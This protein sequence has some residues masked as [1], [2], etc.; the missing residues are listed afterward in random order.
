M[1]V[2][3]MYDVMVMMVKHLMKKLS[4]AESNLIDLLKKK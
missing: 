3:E 1:I 2:M 4:A